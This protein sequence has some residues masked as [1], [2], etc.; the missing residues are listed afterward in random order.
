M[1]PT[2]SRKTLLDMTYKYA[3]PNGFNSMHRLFTER[4]NIYVIKMRR[5]K[6]VIGEQKS[7]LFAESVA[8]SFYGFAFFF[9]FNAFLCPFSH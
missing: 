4:K 3:N 1:N 5:Q 7:R 8:F 2:D 9:M 6:Y